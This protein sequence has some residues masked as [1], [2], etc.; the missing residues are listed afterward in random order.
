M[1]NQFATPTDVSEGMEGEKDV[2]EKS[3][4]LE[5][6]CMGCDQVDI[7]ECFICVRSLLCLASCVVVHSVCGVEGTC[8]SR[9]RSGSACIFSEREAATLR[10]SFFSVTEPLQGFNRVSIDFG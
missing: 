4:L 7:M 3:A 6:S 8:R 2:R 1:L 10:E 9:S 5:G